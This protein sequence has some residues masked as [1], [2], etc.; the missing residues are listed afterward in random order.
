MLFL[1]IMLKK[2]CQ[3]FFGKTIDVGINQTIHGTNENIKSL[4][5]G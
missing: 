4:L 3:L 1:N 2:C 5:E